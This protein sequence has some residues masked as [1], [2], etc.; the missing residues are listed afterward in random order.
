MAATEPAVTGPRKT[1]LKSLPLTADKLRDDE[2]RYSARG[3]ARVA[4]RKKTQ[5]SAVRMQGRTAAAS[6]VHLITVTPELLDIADSL[7]AW[8]HSLDTENHAA[9]KALTFHASHLKRICG[10]PEPEVEAPTT[11]P[12]AVA[13]RT[14]MRKASLQTSARSPSRKSTVGSTGQQCQARPEEDDALFKMMERAA[15]ERQLST[16]ELGCRQRAAQVLE[17][18]GKKGEAVTD[19]TEVPV[20]KIGDKLAISYWRFCSGLK[21][22]RSPTVTEAMRLICSAAVP[23]LGGV[24]YLE[25]FKT[26]TTGSAWEQHIYIFGGLVRDILRRTVGNDIDIGFS[27]PA[28]ELE[29]M[30]HKAGYQNQV[31]GDYIIIGDEN[32]EE[33]LEGMVISFNGIQ[34]PEHADFSMNTLFYDFRNDVIVDKTGRAVPAIVDNKLELPCPRDRWK[35][36]IEINGVR[37]CFR[38]YKFL[39]RGYS[40]EPEEMR[41]VVETLMD[42][43]RKDVDYTIDVGRIALGGLVGCTS[44]EKIEALRVLVF[45]SFNMATNKD[46]AAK[47]PGPRRIGRSYSSD[48]MDASR[49]TAS[50][51][52]R[53]FLSAKSWWEKGW[54]VLLQLAEPAD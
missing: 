51:E 34:P 39:L 9:A 11:T 22:Y 3:S 45:Q 6:D 31:D 27:A 10:A 28:A 30:C 53:T 23:G 20:E 8:A 44:P 49:F 16:E 14:M 36:W 29:E 18:S 48:A 32:G 54:L 12:L 26:L 41:F 47:P 24:T 43:W 4:V 19:L 7:L 13:R 2:I 42:F 40:Y 52:F 25:V 38:Y 37:V 15:Q 50:A 1:L 33:Y 35:S 21:L 5:E 46:A 17:K